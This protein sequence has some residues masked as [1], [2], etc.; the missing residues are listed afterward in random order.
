VRCWGANYAGQLGKD[1]FEDALR[2]QD[3][4]VCCIAD[5]GADLAAG[6]DTS[7]LLIA[8]E[9]A[10][11]RCWGSDYRGQF[12]NGMVG[13]RA[14]PVFTVN[15]FGPG[16]GQLIQIAAGNYSTCVTT[17]YEVRCWGLNADGELGVF[18]PRPLSP[19]PEAVTAPNG[20]V[21]HIVLGAYHGC[22]NG[23]TES[24][25]WGFNHHGQ[26]GNGNTFDQPYPSVIAP[27][28]SYEEIPTW[29][30]G[31]AHTCG[32]FGGTLH[33]WGDNT[34]GQL[35]TGTP[36]PEKLPH[37]VM[38]ANGASAA[39]VA[40]GT[41]QT[42]A[43]T[44]DAGLQCWGTA[45][46]GAGPTFATPQPLPWTTSVDVSLVALGYSHGCVLTTA[47]D[48]RCWGDNSYGQLGIGSFVPQAS[49]VLVP[50]PAIGVVDVDAGAQSL[51]SCAIDAQNG[52]WCWGS[53]SNGQ[54]GDGTTVDSN[55]PVRA[56]NPG[57]SVSRVTVG[58]AHTC[59]KPDS[60]PR[61]LCW[62][63]NA[64]GQLGNG[65]HGYWPT[66]DGGVFVDRLFA[67]GLEQGFGN[68]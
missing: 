57:V 35:G 19:L 26:I 56:A 31:Y 45:L 50:I 64:Y 11:L 47:F 46:G 7:C 49:P 32:A 48:V 21:E 38:L 52:V 68:P 12:G 58:A 17:G 42:C 16:S 62:G 10:D 25:S 13:C 6:G 23:W 9:L 27:A 53:N 29:T 39:Q 41:F 59:L 51:H 22:Y 36:G 2:P 15:L 54:L 43:V 55:V 44:Q 18:A 65:E 8:P 14:T 40:A 37:A 20:H 67:D 28:A 4:G 1:D 3:V 30:A 66:P 24:A 34:W 61:A 60:G 63:D 33:C 5:G